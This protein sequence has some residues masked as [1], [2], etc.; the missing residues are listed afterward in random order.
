MSDCTCTV[1]FLSDAGPQ[2]LIFC[3]SEDAGPADAYDDC[4]QAQYHLA[5]YLPSAVQ[6]SRA[7]TRAE[8][9]GVIYVNQRFQGGPPEFASSVTLEEAMASGQFRVKNLVDPETGHLG[10]TLELEVRSPT[11]RCFPFADV[12]PAEEVLHIAQESISPV[13][14]LSAS[15]HEEEL[16][17][18]SA[19]TSSGAGSGSDQPSL[20]PPRRRRRS[21]SRSDIALAEVAMSPPGSPALTY[22]QQQSM[23]SLLMTAGSPTQ[24]PSRSV[25]PLS[26]LHRA[27]VSDR[28]ETIPDMT[29]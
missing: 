15:S 10:L 3:E 26:P 16:E 5:L 8:Q 29:L 22:Q 23:I 20:T 24:S 7:F 9:L 13:Q 28:L 11:H 14:R 12:T 17:L 2:A 25:L 6:F 19:Y 27:H 18:S 21:H 4:I 1:P